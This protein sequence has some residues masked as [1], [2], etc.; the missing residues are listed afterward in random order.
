[1]PVFELEL[2]IKIDGQ[3]MPAFPLV[4][5]F[6]AVEGAMLATQKAG[7]DVAGT[8][9]VVPGTQMS[10]ALQ[11]LAIASD[12]AVLIR[13]NGQ[14]NADIALNAGGLLIVFDGSLNAGASTNATISN[15]GANPA[16]LTGFWAGT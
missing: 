14:T 9:V 11:G 10:A 1:M 3:L 13:L 2:S 12:Q 5:R 16:N 7:G 4:K 6:Q 8:Y 15:T